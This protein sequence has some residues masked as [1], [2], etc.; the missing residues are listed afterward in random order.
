[1]H[2]DHQ[3]LQWVCVVRCR[4]ASTLLL[5]VWYCLILNSRKHTFQQQTAE[6]YSA[7]G[8]TKFSRFARA[9]R[10]HRPNSFQGLLSAALPSAKS[11]FHCP[12]SR[13]ISTL[14]VSSR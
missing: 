2:R 10:Q 5:R 14:S 8:P 12:S 4:G 13:S 6:Y 1:M 11:T 9:V 7:K 3:V